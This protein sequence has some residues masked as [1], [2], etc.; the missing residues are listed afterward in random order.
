MNAKGENGVQTVSPNA[1]SVL[2]TEL[3]KN[4]MKHNKME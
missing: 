1:L 2:R 4:I 3:D